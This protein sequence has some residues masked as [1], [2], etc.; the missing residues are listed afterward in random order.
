MYGHAN[1]SRTAV[2]Y[3]GYCTAIPHTYTY[4]LH[5]DECLSELKKGCVLQEESIMAAF[6]TSC[7]AGVLDVLHGVPARKAGM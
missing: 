3:C 5:R 2:A 6:R 7:T 4:A 1:S